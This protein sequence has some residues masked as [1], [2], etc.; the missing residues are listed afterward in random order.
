MEKCKC[1]ACGS[2]NTH[3]TGENDVVIV[4][5]PDDEEYPATEWQCFDCGVVWA[6]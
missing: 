5:G 2:K 4:A 3:P 6:E 1:I